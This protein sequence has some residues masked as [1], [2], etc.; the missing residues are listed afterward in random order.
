[1][2]VEG[3][4]LWNVITNFYCSIITVTLYYIFIASFGP[5]D[6]TFV[7]GA[8]QKNFLSFLPISIYF[9]SSLNVKYKNKTEC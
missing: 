8:E 9:I 4:E 6:K 5:A 2:R 3:P 7:G 1:M